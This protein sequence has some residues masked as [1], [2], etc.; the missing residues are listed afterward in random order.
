MNSQ[1][2]QHLRD[3]LKEQKKAKEKCTWSCAVGQDANF[4]AGKTLCPELCQDKFQNE[5]NDLKKQIKGL[6]TGSH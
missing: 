2:I 6:Q 5:I 3:R 1:E 4:Y